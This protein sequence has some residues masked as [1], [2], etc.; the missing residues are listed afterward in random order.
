MD[1]AGKL[2]E[3]L[4]NRVAFLDGAMGTM[5]M[6]RGMPA[7]V[8]V[9]RWAAAHPDI[10]MSI[11]QSFL[12]AG[13]DIILA[14]TFGGSRFNLGDDC[15][16]INTLLAETALKAAAGNRIAAASIGPSGK[17][18]YPVGDA[19]WTE[20]YNSF[21]VQAEALTAAGIDV[22]FLETFTDPR[23]LKAAV[24]ACRDAC[25]DGF[26]SAHLTFT[27]HGRTG[28]GT[29]PTALAVLCEQLAVDAVGANCST[30]PEGLLP[31]INQ[32]CRSS[33][34]HVTVEPN[35]GLPDSRG[36]Y[37][38][39]PEQFA[40]ATEEM[41]WAG[42]SILGGCC[43][44]TPEHIKALRTAVG[45]RTP[46]KRIVEPVAAFSSVDTLVPIGGAM[47]KV[48]ESVN[49]TGR[50][51]LKRAIRNG[52]HQFVISRARAQEDADLLDINMGL[53]RLVPAGMVHRVAAGLCTGAPLS[54]DLSSPENV[55]T[56]FQELGGIGLLNSML[57]TRQSIEERAPVLLRHGGYA[58]LLPI[59]ENGLPDSPA[60]RLKILNRGL[61]ILKESG[62]P[63]HRVF[64]DP[65]VKA[66]ATGADP[67]ITV[68]TLKLFKK[69]GLRS[70]AGVSNI[71]HGLPHRAGLNAAFLS[72][73]AA[74]GLDAG[75]VNV[76]DPLTAPL[77]AGAGVLS[78]RID[79]R[80]IP[81]P[82]AEDMDEEENGFT[83]LRKAL[84]TGDCSAS[85]KTGSALLQEGTGAREI[86]TECLAPAMD[87]LGNLYSAR[88]IFLPHLIAGAEAA[89]ALMDVLEPALTTEGEASRGTIVLA[90][91]RGDI[92]DIG[93]NLV[94]L[95]LSNAGFNVID[96]GKDIPSEKIVEAAEKHSA[97][98][99]A[100]SALMSTTAS[101]MEEVISLLR[102]K[103]LNI[104]VMVGGAVITGEFAREIGAHYGG[105]AYTAVET[106][107]KLIEI[108]HH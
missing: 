3:L 84:V 29:S 86:I 47:L 60:D 43:G 17:L 93:K 26:I 81:I 100:L 96:L 66:V 75:I 9:E 14:C 65:I 103:G 35:A 45:V 77:T 57:S 5:L 78:G 22:F 24:L 7:G 12:E 32:L 33:S 76:N 106:A 49:P 92:H 27:D 23:Q 31:V 18:I 68:D 80:D 64:A 91:V 4:Q 15:A 51:G 16:G 44:T 71:S 48:G 25:P 52:D 36:R 74:E 88:K 56:A 8:S 59:D 40:G 104:P 50:K 1:Q 97:D 19:S 99:V 82:P 54:I 85:E 89:R 53:E 69:S 38:M 28:S 41:A 34:R 37:L 20:V 46:E 10:L 39:S 108:L 63:S 101:R 94:S 79:P 95:F 55:E 90:T 61:A 6:N 13:S 67:R 83:S 62:F 87:R 2:R 98:A 73:L 102:E 72:I 30:G 11:H 70:I 58:V 105:D 107:G 21:S 42:A